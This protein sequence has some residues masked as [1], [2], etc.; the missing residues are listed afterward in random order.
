MG[1]TWRFTDIAS[2]IVGG[3]G[4]GVVGA[5]GVLWSERGG[6]GHWENLSAETKDLVKSKFGRV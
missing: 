3:W 5:G 1:R 4:L 2:A 6:G